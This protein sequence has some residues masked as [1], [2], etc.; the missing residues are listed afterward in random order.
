MTVLNVIVGFKSYTVKHG[1]D[2]S[3]ATQLYKVKNTKNG[4]LICSVC[5]PVWLFAW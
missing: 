3:A 2:V 4:T 5:L 1:H